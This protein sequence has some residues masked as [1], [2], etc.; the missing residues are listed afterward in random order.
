MSKIQ[1]ALDKINAARAQSNAVDVSSQLYDVADKESGADSSYTISEM[2]QP[3]PLSPD[4]KA[5]MKIVSTD[6]SDRRVFNAFR[7]LRTSILQ[8]VAK[9]SP[10]IMVTSCQAESGNSFVALNLAAAISMDETKTSLLLDCNFNHPSFSD[11]P[12]NT[13]NIGL[14]NYLSADNCTISDIILPTGIPRMR[15]IPAGNSEAPMSE[16]FTSKRLYQLFDDIKK[17]YSERYII[18]DAPPISENADTRILAQ[19]CDY[20]VLVIPYGK[21]TKDTILRT[22]R[23]IGKDKLLGTVFNNEPVVPKITK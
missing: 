8:R 2:H 10:I 12:A 23:L 5:R 15:V 4:E 13:P 17:R 18:V 22:A 7:D 11:L 3:E 6:M 16:Y 20:V 19:V 9:G 1:E 14:K 21:L